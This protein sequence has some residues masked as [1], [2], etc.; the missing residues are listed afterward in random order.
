MHQLDSTNVVEI[1][2]SKTEQK[3]RTGLGA[4]SNERSIAAR[5]SLALSRDTLFDDTAAKIGIYRSSFRTVGGIKQ[6]D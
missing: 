2:L 3:N 5:P 6:C 1:I 4:E